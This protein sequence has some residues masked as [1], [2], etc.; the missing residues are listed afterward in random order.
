M[1]PVLMPSDIFFFTF[2][3]LV[4]LFL[5][6]A[7]RREYY[8]DAGRRIRKNG[9]AMVCLAVIVA[10]GFLAAL[11]SVHYRPVVREAGGALQKDKE[12]RPLHHDVRSLFDT[13]FAKVY[14]GITDQDGRIQVS[15]EKSYSAPLA[16]GGFDRE[17]DRDT[18]E[19]VRKALAHPRAHWLGTDK[20]GGDVLFRLLKGVR[21][22]LIVS[23]VTTMIVIPFAI[24][25]GVT[26]GY[27]GGRTDDII[28]FTYIT[29]GSIPSILLIS[30]MMIIVNVRME[31]AETTDIF[32]K[33]DKIILFLCCILGIIGWSGLCRLLRAETIKLRELDF[34]KAAQALGVKSPVIIVRHIIPNLLHVV[35]I[36]SILS[37]SGL[38]MV[39]AIL[40]YIQIGV[41][42]TIE[43]WGRIVDG[44]REQLARDPVIW[45]PVAG[46]F[47]FMFI[48]V[49]AVNI[50][51]D[52][53]RDALD[54]KLRT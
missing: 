3:A 15:L 41:P 29:M 7:R 11:D 48:L 16:A 30:A 28:Q 19:W 44:A 24:F 6:W 25:F 23:L 39:E 52:A 5:L 47:A 43:S 34:V 17:Q 51:G 10:Y 20:S 4:G 18:R 27:Y 32:L 53:L 36:S 13:L 26:A 35:L 2:I 50:F 42:S 8:C 12:G 37:F 49:L 21:T 33:D 40:S 54:P 1:K 22:A 45:W 46:A 9:W 38:V 31:R 14:G